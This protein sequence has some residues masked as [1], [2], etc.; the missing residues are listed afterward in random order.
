L[1]FNI[2][3]ENELRR[4]KLLRGFYGAVLPTEEKLQ[5]LQQSVCPH[6]LRNLQGWML[7]KKLKTQ[8][9]FN[10]VLVWFGLYL[11]CILSYLW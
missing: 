4:R 3:N 10:N 8:I 11:V 6:R 7:N 9:Q 2:E 1:G 5:A